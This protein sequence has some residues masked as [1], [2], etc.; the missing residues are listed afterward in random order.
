M[1]PKYKYKQLISANNVRTLILY[2]ASMQSSRSVETKILLGG[3]GGRA[4]QSIGVSSEKLQFKDGLIIQQ[5]GLV[6]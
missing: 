3:K 2:P 1:A 4:K 5:T 6:P